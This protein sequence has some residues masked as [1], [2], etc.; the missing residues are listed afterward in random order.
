MNLI[1]DTNP[2]LFFNICCDTIIKTIQ[3]EF[4]SLIKG[5]IV[6]TKQSFQSPPSLPLLRKERLLQMKESSLE[7]GHRAKHNVCWHC[8]P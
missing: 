1:V 2:G 6:Q 4:S 7:T 8:Q 5:L 3:F